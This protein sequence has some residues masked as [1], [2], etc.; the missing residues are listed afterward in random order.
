MLAEY[1]GGGCTAGLVGCRCC[2]GANGTGF[3]RTGAGGFDGGVLLAGGGT[4]AA[5]L[6]GAW[7]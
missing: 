4:G 1:G 6:G 2:G 7:E 5:R 3:G